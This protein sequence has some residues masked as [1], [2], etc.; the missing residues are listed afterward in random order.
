LLLDRLN[1][2]VASPM[3]RALVATVAR[4][5]DALLRDGAADPADVLLYAAMRATVTRDIDVLAEATMQPDSS[6]L[7]RA[8]ARF[9]DEGEE[10][11][12]AARLAALDTLLTEIPAG[13][14]PRL[15]NLRNT[16]SRL[17]RSLGA[18]QAATSLRSLADPDAS[19]LSV[20]EDAL[21]VLAQLTEIALRRCGR[22]E[23]AERPSV[24][25][26]DYPL[27]IAA[28]RAVEPF[29]DIA[30]E[31]GAPIAAVTA[32][33][34]AL[35]P[36]A[37]AELC[38][39]VLPRMLE[40]PAEPPIAAGTGSAA[41]R[42]DKAQVIDARLPSWIPS[43]RTL[44][45]FYVQRQ[46]GGGAA[47]TV[48]VVT[49]AEERHD[50][51]SERFALK[52]PEYDA[53]AARSLSEADFL[54]LFREEA[55][56]LLAVPE[57]E[58]LAR[59]VTF[60]A[61]ARPKP[62]LVMELIEGIRCDQLITSRLL[63]VPRA[64]A[65][66]DGVLAGLQAMHSVGVGHLDIKPSNV[67]LRDTSAPVLVDF[68]LAGRNLR[69]GCA[70]SAYGAPEVWGIVPDGVTPTPLTADLYSFGC[71]AY[72]VLT[73]ET[74]FNAPNEVALISAHLSHDGMPPPI[75]RF[76]ESR[77]TSALS[78]LLGQCLR[79]SPK[80]R[81]TVTEVRAELGAIQAGF[82][83]ATWPIRA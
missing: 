15:D 36:R 4:A 6:R 40:L 11:S 8:Y 21:D 9:V 68:G 51:N 58:N 83:S 45:G 77:A 32:R 13:A 35:L 64:F 75:K 82:T 27:F 33:A 52:V 74:L 80:D 31:L 1:R 30:A 81:G 79:R 14:S 18:V 20:L 37:L 19:P 38:A 59:F 10:A 22:D 7:L 48:F 25:S 29:A 12:G 50:P 5:L 39:G 42:V 65:I 24:R 69:P 2:E 67:V 66:L 16:L 3:H 53:T 47:G 71:F 62:I 73:A 23:E 26:A 17:A 60:D 78:Q 76:A 43:R 72:E 46:L 34:F 63:T 57:H 54:K 70:T 49:R 56:A 55:G 44:G 41:H 28:G 61:G